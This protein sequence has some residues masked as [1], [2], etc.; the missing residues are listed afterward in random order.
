MTA[1]GARTNEKRAYSFCGTIEYMAPEVVKAGPQGHDIAVDWWSVGVLT[2]ELLTGASPFTVEGERNTQQEISRR[3]LKT[4]PPIPDDLG[5]EVSDFISK[6]LVK[7]P[8]KRLGGGDGDASELKSHSF[9]KSLDWD[10]LA[11]KNIPAPFKP[12]IRYVIHK[13]TVFLVN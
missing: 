7:D 4:E 11:K 10:E 3:I 8:R 12:V 13:H 9:F 6:L 1:S 5:K 2:Y